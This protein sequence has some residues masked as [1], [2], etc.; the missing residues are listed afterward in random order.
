MSSNNAIIPLPELG[1]KKI[2]FS[3]FPTRMQAFI[4]KNWD[5]VPKERLAECIGCT[6]EQI[7]AQ[8]SKMGLSPQ[9]DVSA[10]LKQGYISVIKVNWQLIPYEQLLFLLE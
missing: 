5:I 10:W 7:E 2:E 3:H 9:R 4:F 8:A 1:D 6:T